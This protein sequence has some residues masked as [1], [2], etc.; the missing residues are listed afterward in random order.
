MKYDTGAVNVD[1]ARAQTS[2]GLV[3][4]GTISEVKIPIQRMLRYGS[5]PTLEEN[6][7]IAP[8]DT[9]K[10]VDSRDKP[11]SRRYTC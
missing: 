7:P 4:P 6:R 8:Y 1:A 11:L 9:V 5:E 10:Q 2:H 3:G